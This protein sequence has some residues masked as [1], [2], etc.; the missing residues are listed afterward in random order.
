M[1]VY[2]KRCTFAR[3]SNYWTMSDRLICKEIE[4]Q[5]GRSM[6]TAKDFDWLAVQINERLN[7]S[8]GVNT[9]KRAWGFNGYEGTA[10][11]KSTLDILARFAGYPNHEVFEANVSD[12]SSDP[13]K[14][15]HLYTRQLAE[16]LAVDCK[17]MPDRECT[18]QHLGNCKFVVTK[19]KNSKLSVGDTFECEL[20]VENEPLY[21][22]NLV[23]EG[24]PPMSYI[25]G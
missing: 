15:H 3:K 18:F 13:I 16:G 19:V 14:S 12:I 2:E 20:F 6:T 24:H 7:A 23:H 4:R 9:L 1:A 10:P 17:W 5:T 25:A 22:T 21:L 11:Q 8:L